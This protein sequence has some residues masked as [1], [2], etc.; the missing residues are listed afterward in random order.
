MMCIIETIENVIN[1]KVLKGLY[2]NKNMKKKLRQVT[3]TSVGVTFTKEEQDIRDMKV[4][5]VLDLS[6]M[7]VEKKGDNNG[8]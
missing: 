3:G 6:D 5:D 7:V 8:N 1:R 4:G 2:P